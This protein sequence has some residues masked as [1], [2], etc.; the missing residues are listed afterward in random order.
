MAFAAI[1]ENAKSPNAKA[2]RGWAI[3]GNSADKKV[4]R[5]AMFLAAAPVPVPAGAAVT[6]RLRHQ[7]GFGDHNV[8]RFRL[9]T[10]PL[11][12]S[13]VKLDGGSGLPGNLLA[14]VTGDPAKRS[15]ADRKALETWFRANADHPE[16]RARAALDAAKAKR[17]EVE[18]SFPSVMVMK[19]KPAPR[20]AFVLHRGDTTSPANRSRASSPP[21][22]PRSRGSAAEPPRTRPL[23]RLRRAPPH[24]ARL[25]STASGSASSAPG[26]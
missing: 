18:Q 15:E 23:A 24:R 8:G 3:D 2:A 14:I 12:P 7:S 16:K 19:E 6:V 17:T 20:E 9:S 1:L 4:A 26:S 25:D 10:T 11:E 5:R 13:L 21:S 22:F